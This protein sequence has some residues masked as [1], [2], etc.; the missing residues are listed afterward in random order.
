MH[1]TRANEALC[2]YGNDNIHVSSTSTGLE[3]VFEKNLNLK[4]P[5]FR[6]LGF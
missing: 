2:E 1:L 4:S 3:N 6:F 5:K